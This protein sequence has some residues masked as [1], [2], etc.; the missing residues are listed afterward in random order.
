MIHGQTQIRLK[1][2]FFPPSMVYW[3]FMYATF[4]AR[5]KSPMKLLGGLCV[6]ACVRAC[7][8]VLVLATIFKG[9]RNLYRTLFSRRNHPQRTRA[10]SLSRLH[11]HTQTHHTR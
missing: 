6:R 1:S 9:N 8:R 7:V 11:D 10:S 5:S 2:L 4:H 3:H